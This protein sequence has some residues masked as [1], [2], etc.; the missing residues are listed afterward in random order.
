[1]KRLFLFV[2][3]ALA[4][5][6]TLPAMTGHASDDGPDRVYFDVTGHYVED[7][8]LDFWREYGGIQTFGYPL[9]P[10]FE[11]DGLTVQYFE[12][13]I[14]ELH[15][16][17]SSDHRVLLRRLGAEARD[18][19]DLGHRWP[20]DPHDEAD[21]GRYFPAT[22][23][24]L[25]HRFVEYWEANGGLRIF[26]Y[27]LSDQFRHHGTR[28]QF[29]ERAIFEHHPD[30]PPEW[31]ILFERLGAQAAERDGIDI[32]PQEHDGET[33]AYHED[34]WEK[35]EETSAQE[36]ASEDA[37]STRPELPAELRIDRIGVRST[38][39][40]LGRTPQGAMADPVGWDNVS[41]FNEGPRPGEQGNAAVA[42]HLDRPGGAPAIFW[43]LNQLRPGDRVS[44]ITEDNEE[45]VFEV[46]EV[47]QFHINNP[48]TSRIFGRTDDYNMNLITCAGRWDT[49]IGM[50]DERL[51]AYTTLV[52][53]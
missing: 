24:N 5:F 14:L 6:I 42:G 16:D 10:Q 22:Q 39:E 27:P 37:S 25:S 21:S 28:V 30:N 32:S 52:S 2:F 20:F 35:P 11:Q 15:P 43:N 7:E 26:G 44:V 12:R 36:P 49:S 17:N 18:D 13:H 19:R 8:F 50:Y 41:W 51:V 1:M 4:A 38:F 3:V 33:P 53:D 47:E 29:T 23:Q 31:E 46:T 34:L 45:L 40:H 48:P 9:T